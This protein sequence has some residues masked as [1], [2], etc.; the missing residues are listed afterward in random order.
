MCLLCSC[1][2]FVLSHQTMVLLLTIWTAEV[3]TCN[4]YTNCARSC[5]CLVV[6]A[7]LAL[8]HTHWYILYCYVFCDTNTNP[9]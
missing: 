8:H 2:E 6:F 5:L 9:D 7:D 3:S 1:D 4:A